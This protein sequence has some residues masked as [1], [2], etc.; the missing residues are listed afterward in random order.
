MGS[1]S[2]YNGEILAGMH[3]VVIVT[4]NYRL[5]I[6]GFFNIPGTT[7][8]GN[9]GLM[10]QILALEWVKQH[11]GDFG[12]DA[13]KVTIFGESAGAGSVSLLMLS[14]LTKG[15]F[16]KVIAQSGSALNYW[17]VHLTTNTS[18]AEGFASGMGCKELKT[19]TDC[20]RKKSLK[21]ILKFQMARRL[22]SI[23][24][25]PSVDDNVIHGLPFEQLKAGKLP[26]SNVDLMTGFNSDEG[27]MFMPN[28]KQ[29]NNASYKEE[30]RKML[31]NR[32]GD[33]IALETKLASFHYQTFLKPDS[34]NLRKGFK[35]FLDDYMFRE[36]IVKLAVEWSKKNK[37]TYLY[38]FG[39]L[40]THPLIPQWGVAHSMEIDFVFGMAYLNRSILNYLVRNFTKED[41]QMSSKMMKMWTDFTKNGHPGE[42]VAPIDIVKRKYFVINR[43]ITIK[44]NYDP[45]MMA[46]WNDYVPEILKIKEE[47]KNMKWG[48]VANYLRVDTFTFLAVL[49][50]SLAA[51]C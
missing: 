10:D 20:L 37:N 26:V 18:Q 43:N 34:S 47:R 28:V 48:S 42:G 23:I 46:F 36:G 11:I 22:D 30:I 1:G 6:L 14:P 35:I 41:R 2:D 45:K 19:A 16:S 31:V 33:D 38:H 40:P 5:G 32:Y 13:N 25:S 51:L 8:K 44:E 27:T 3:N 49:A 7:T 29:W 50:L 17:A 9:Y 21:E 4:I 12:G 15:L 39:Y 24:L